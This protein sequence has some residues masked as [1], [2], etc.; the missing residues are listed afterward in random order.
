MMTTEQVRVA[1]TGNL[2]SLDAVLHNT[3]TALRPWLVAVP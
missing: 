3:H 2:L 1:S